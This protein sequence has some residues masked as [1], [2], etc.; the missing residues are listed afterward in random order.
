MLDERVLLYLHVPKTAGSS[1]TNVIYDQYNDSTESCEEA[2][3]FC[4]GVYYYPGEPGFV[5]PCWADR[6][7]RIV[8]PSRI[9]KALSRGDLRVVAGHFMFGLHALIHRPATY[10]TMLRH[11]IERIV[12]LYYHLKRWPQYWDNEPWLARAGLKPLEP[13][14]SLDDFIRDYPLRELENDQT[15]RIAGKDPEFG[16]CTRSLLETAKSNIE[17]HF[18]LVGVTDRFEETLRVA[19]DVLGWSTQHQAGQQLVNEFRQPTSLIAPKT[20]ETILERNALDL[21]LYT[22][23]NAWL[24][25]RLSS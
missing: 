11:P 17:R 1:M 21:E 22:F 5:R 10:A 12:S 25:E 9:L 4:E 18:S 13:E 24:N 20:R 16:G 19:A 3:W 2:G 6:P 14:T 7:Y 15:R 8:P 23:A